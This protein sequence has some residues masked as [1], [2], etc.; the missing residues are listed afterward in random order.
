MTVF[1]RLIQ[2]RENYLKKEENTKKR[3]YNDAKKKFQEFIEDIIDAFEDTLIEKVQ[4]GKVGNYEL[5]DIPEI[6][7]PVEGLYSQQYEGY[8]PI[9]RFQ[10]LTI[11]DFKEKS[12]YLSKEIIKDE[13]LLEF[14]EILEAEGLKPYFIVKHRGK[15]AL[16]TISL[17]VVLPE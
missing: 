1:K 7:H 16:R 9:D 2:E 4:Q 8:E 6:T 10:L 12:Y 11:K 13:V 17:G 14:W 3:Y 5:L 15:L